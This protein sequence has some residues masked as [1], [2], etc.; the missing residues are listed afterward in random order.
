MFPA[1]MLMAISKLDDPAREKARQCAEATLEAAVEHKLIE[2]NP[3]V[4]ARARGVLAVRK[5]GGGICVCV[6][7]CARMCA[8]VCT[9]GSCSQCACA[10][11]IRERDGQVCGGGRATRIRVGKASVILKSFKFPSADLVTVPHGPIRRLVGDT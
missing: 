10:C 9:V 2:A 8:C 7:V 4:R 1:Q 11:R 3:Q 5:R 6:C